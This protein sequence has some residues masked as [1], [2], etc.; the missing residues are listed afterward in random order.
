MRIRKG[1]AAILCAALLAGCGKSGDTGE[2]DQMEPVKGKYVESSVDLPE[3]LEG[4]TVKQLFTAGGKIHLF[5]LKAEGDRTIAGEWELQEDGFADVTRPWLET[6]ELPGGETRIEAKLMQTREGGQYLYADYIREGVTEPGTCLWKEENGE[7]REIT[8]EKWRTFNEEWGGYEA[9]AGIDVLDNDTLLA[10]TYTSL[11]LLNGSDGSVMESEA[12][13]VPYDTMVSDG[14]NVW[15]CSSYQYD[16]PELVIEKC[17]EGKYSQASAVTA[18]DNMTGA[19][20]CIREDGT[21]ILAGE[22][23]IF[24]GK[25]SPGTD[26]GMTWEK[27]LGG[28]ETDFGLSGCWCI[29]LGAPQDGAVY[30]LFQQS[31]GGYRLRRYE[32]DPDAVIEIIEELTLYTVRENYLLNQA[33][34]MYHREHPEILITIRNV[35]SKYEEETDYNAVYQELNTMLMGE[36]APDILV[37][38]HLDIASYAEKGLLEDLGDVVTPMEESGELLANITGAYIREDGHRYV[39]PLEFGITMAVG[40]DIRAEDMLSME[41]LSEF[42]VGSRDSYMGPQTVG[43]LVEKFYPYFCDGIVADKALDKAALGKYLEQLKKIG[44]NCGIIDVREKGEKAYNMWDLASGAKLALEDIEGFND[45]MFPLAMMDYIQGEFAVFENCFLPMV[46]TGICTK[47]THKETA[48]D[49]LAFAL[50]EE[51]QVSDPYGGFPVNT[52]ALEKKAHS[53]R[54]EA[55]AEAS[56]DAEGGTIEFRISDFSKETADRLVEVCKGLYRPVGEDEKI[57]EVLT[58]ALENYLKGGQSLEDTVQRI[59]D[60]L[61]MYLGE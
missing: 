6:V 19:K 57:R 8:P 30:A 21:L 17:P 15:I 43:E 51:M 7:A 33:A 25:E 26:G 16:S 45:C 18:P 12:I 24:S 42:L 27:L 44:D 38:D 58:Q 20:Y 9:V 34:A 22:E 32:Y 59:D 49:F 29:G 4:W 31:G 10:A 61:K 14:E 13:T 28:V 5:A 53:D 47:S 2:I 55:E 56:I 46:Q 60:G 37:L 41:K 48:M 39:V 1:I 54:S 52:A 36:A 35:Y 3:E 11:D 50:S 23:G 40:R